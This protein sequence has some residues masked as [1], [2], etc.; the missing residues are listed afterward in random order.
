M[1][2]TVISTPWTENNTV[3]CMVGPV[4][5]MIHAIAHPNPGTI[6][7]LILQKGKLR[8]RVWATC[9][10]HTICM[11][12]S[13]VSLLLSL[14]SCLNHDASGICRWSFNVL[15]L[16]GWMDRWMV[17]QCSPAAAPPTWLDRKHVGQQAPGRHWGRTRGAQAGKPTAAILAQGL[18]LGFRGWGGQL[19]R[20]LQASQREENLDDSGFRP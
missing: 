18:L 13:G 17:E 7:N 16:N 20:P 6:I 15:W 2:S 9:P 10:S 12:Q 1:G 5:S 8:H 11:S 19:G 3:P 14:D 4:P